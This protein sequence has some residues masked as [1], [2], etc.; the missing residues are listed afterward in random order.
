MQVSHCTLEEIAVLQYFPHQSYQKTYVRLKPDIQNM[1][2]SGGYAYCLRVNFWTW[3]RS[4]LFGAPSLHIY[5]NDYI[6]GTGIVLDGKF[7]H[8]FKWK[9]LLKL[10]YFSWNSFCISSHLPNLY[11]S[12]NGKEVLNFTEGNQ[13]E[14]IDISTISLG[15]TH[16]TGQIS[17]LNIWNRSLSQVEILE[18]SLGCNSDFVLKSNPDI[19]LWS[20]VN[21]T[22]Q[23][24]SANKTT[25]PK[26]DLCQLSNEAKLKTKK[27]LF[28]RNLDYAYNFK[29]CKNMNGE[30]FYPKNDNDTQYLLEN[31]G[32]SLVNSICSGKFWVPFVR[33]G[34]AENGWIYDSK[35]HQD[36]EHSFSPWVK[37]N[38]NETSTQNKCMFFDISTKHF[39][40]I[41]CSTRMLCTFC[42]I[43]QKR[44][45]FNLHS[46]CA[47]S[48][49][50]MDTMYFFVPQNPGY[51]FQ[52]FWG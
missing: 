52:D 31:I 20:S 34:T 33:S 35:K 13:Q 16:F 14:T 41:D 29:Q 43:D 38:F 46:D 44:N 51:Y 23:G 47:I 1:L 4:F 5:L 39:K 48:E 12:I 45:V 49:T 37:S 6:K 7:S 15:S 9:S 28:P 18:Y 42:E 40:N 26:K 21:I 27:V 8:T 17:D 25:I 2:T 24:N 30:M 50:E 11:F 10:S 22:I 3:D 19:L 32:S 36:E